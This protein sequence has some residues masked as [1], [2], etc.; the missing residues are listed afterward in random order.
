MEQFDALIFSISL[1]KKSKP[2]RRLKLS[3]DVLRL[4]KAPDNDIEWKVTS[5]GTMS[6][7]VSSDEDHEEDL[8]NIINVNELDNLEL[9]TN[10]KC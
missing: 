2:K 7:A 10:N 5:E 3:S 6:R 8:E 1:N 9:E 4:L